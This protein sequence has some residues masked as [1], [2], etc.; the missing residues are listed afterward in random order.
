MIGAALGQVAVVVARYQTCFR[1]IHQIN[2][3]DLCDMNLME[4]FRGLKTFLNAINS[5][6]L[7]CS[8][9]IICE[10]STEFGCARALSVK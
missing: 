9:V 1:L 6:G 3:M 8:W 10:T 7:R 5:S 2:V 4:Y